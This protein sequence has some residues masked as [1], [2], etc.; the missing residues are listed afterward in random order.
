MKL[1]TDFEFRTKRRETE[2]MMQLRVNNVFE[3][4]FAD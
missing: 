2:M 4:S 3:S 1:K